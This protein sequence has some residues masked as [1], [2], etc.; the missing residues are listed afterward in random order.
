MLARLRRFACRFDSPFLTLLV[1]DWRLPIAL[2]SVAFILAFCFTSTLK[3]WPRTPANARTEIRISTLD[4]LQACALSRSARKAEGRGD[5]DGA[6]NSWSEALAND[7]LNESIGIPYLEALARSPRATDAV[8]AMRVALWFSEFSTNAEIRRLSVAA[9]ERNKEW[10]AVLQFTEG[11]VNLPSRTRLAMI[12]ALFWTGNHQRAR[13]CLTTPRVGAS[14]EFDLYSGAL[15]CLA[16]SHRESRLK[17]LV[18]HVRPGRLSV[19]SLE[20]LLAVCFE[21]RDLPEFEEQLGS[22][23]KITDRTLPFDLLHARLL[24]DLGRRDAARDVAAKFP[25]PSSAHE[26]FRAAS[27]LLKLG[28][29]EDALLLLRDH[30]EKFDDS[31]NPWILYAQLLLDNRDRNG[32]RQI[33]S[34][35]EKSNPSVDAFGAAIEVLLLP[36]QTTLGRLTNALADLPPSR[37]AYLQYFA[38]QS[39]T[40]S[41][42]PGMAVDTLLTIEPFHAAD[43]EFY[44]HLFAAAEAARDARQ[45]RRAAE[46]RY[47]LAPADVLSMGNYAA[48]LTMFDEQPEVAAELTA[49]CAEARPSSPSARINHAAALINKEHFGSADL[50][51]RQIDE[52]SMPRADQNQLR[53]IKVKR[54]IKLGLQGE[55]RSLAAGLNKSTLYSRQLE[56]LSEH[57]L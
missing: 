4:F 1:F 54:A 35:L 2:A 43:I 22:L 32:L 52:G 15:E 7:P 45:M 47:Q 6:I 10:A 19:E 51:L 3:V 44:D 29:R 46:R 55:A 18:T 8:S 38:A 17:E 23:K 41:G 25:P 14:A 12:K 30:L 39:L 40:V 36:N 5:L 20:V 16:G 34:Q 31:I 28:L 21:L 11:A 13:E 57:K 50:I 56:W 26:T 53:F 27:T 42:F 33:V 48:M 9:A 24:S 37:H 49:R